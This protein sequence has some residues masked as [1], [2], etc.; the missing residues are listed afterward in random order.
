[1]KRIISLTLAALLL[2]ATLLTVTSC[3]FGME[4]KTGYTQLR[5]HIVD[6]VGYDTA[7]ALNEYASIKVVT[8]EGGDTEIHAT[9]GAVSDDK[10]PV[11]ITLKMNGSVEKAALFCEIM[12]I[13][14]T[15]E[16][17][18]GILTV[19]ST[20]SA[21]VLLT[22]YTGN[23][24]IAFTSIENISY[25]REFGNREFATSLLNTLLLSLDIYM[26]EVMD[27][28][29]RDIGFIVLSDKY[30]AEAKDVEAEEDLG[31]AF[32][33]ARL[34]MAGRMILMGMGMIF[35]VLA[36]LWIVLLIF[37][38]IFAK[39]PAKKSAPKAEKP[40]AAPTAAPAKKAAPAAPAAPAASV[41]PAAGQA[42]DGQ[43]IAVIT[44]A[45]AA[46]IEADPALSSQFASGF[47]VVSFKKTDKSTRR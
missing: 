23:D 47:R 8:L 28:S 35:L 38:A 37:K 9:I 16:G 40:A 41:A 32:S 12:T 36:I 10:T 27:L 20:G 19:K 42:A 45:V 17:A 31:G 46:A 44:A 11:R 30:M 21:E 43:L 25:F 6:Q 29:V 39:D 5:D 24:P 26:N 4:S 1:M 14:A 33:S 22:H 34:Q 18:E 13:T 15:E 3:E 7:L 2:V